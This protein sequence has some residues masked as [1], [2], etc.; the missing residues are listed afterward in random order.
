MDF[1][2]P[3]G[4]PSASLKS[5][6]DLDYGGFSISSSNPLRRLKNVFSMIPRH[7]L[8][9]I[10]QRRTF[11]MRSANCLRTQLPVCISSKF[12][13][14]LYFQVRC[15]SSQVI[16][17]PCYVRSGD[18]VCG[19]CQAHNFSS[20]MLCFECQS[21]ITD[22]R[23]FYRQGDWHCP[24]CNLSVTSLAQSAARTKL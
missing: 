4:D 7:R 1:P 3:P 12:H 8:L 18:W 19:K 11:P 17:V 2:H 13:P 22:G 15:N 6:R 16:K 5:S 24:T 14:K 21:V 23:I 20:R 9:A 10:F